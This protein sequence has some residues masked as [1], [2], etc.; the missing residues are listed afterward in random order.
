MRLVVSALS[1]LFLLL[2]ASS[3]DAARTSRK[4]SPPCRLPPHTRMLAA[5]PQAQIYE[6]LETES[7]EKGIYGCVYGSRRTYFL[8]EP[9]PTVGTPSGIEGITLETLAGPMAA[10]EYTSSGPGPG[11]LGSGEGYAEWI[12][13]VRDLRNGRILHRV[14]TGTSRSARDVGSGP[15]MAIVV[16]A[17]GSVAWMVESHFEPPTAENDFKGNSEYA[18]EAVDKTG[19][20][21]LAS[22]LGIDPSSLALA[23]G[24]VYWTQNGRPASSVLH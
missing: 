21:L 12:I 14:P 23:D 13:V 16:Q 20:R 15:A 8:G 9:S 22:G 4:A 19:G 7:Q 10:Y 5:D 24:I 18:V 2:A 3:G 6:K 11:G 17:D 1:V